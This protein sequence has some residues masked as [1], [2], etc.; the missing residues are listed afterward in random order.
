MLF[1]VVD[2]FNLKLSM[3]AQKN[4]EGNISTGISLSGEGDHFLTLHEDPL[5]LDSTHAPLL[6]GNI[7]ST[8]LSQTLS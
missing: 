3:V 2:V 1:V 8:Y 4:W 7:L 6:R 5:S